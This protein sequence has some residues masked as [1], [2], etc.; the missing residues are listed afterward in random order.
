MRMDK[1]RKTREANKEAVKA[2]IDKA[3]SY[4]ITPTKLARLAGVALGSV[5]EVDERVL[6]PTDVTTR[7]ILDAIEEIEK[8]KKEEKKSNSR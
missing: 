4:H 1:M 5:T 7:K 2:A 6:G 8:S 3:I